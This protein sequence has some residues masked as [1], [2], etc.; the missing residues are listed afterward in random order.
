MAVDVVMGDPAHAAERITIQVGPIKQTLYVSD[1]E[2]FAK[3]GQVPTRLRLYQSLL[4]PEIR[5]VLNKRVALDPAMA[6]RMRVSACTFF[7]S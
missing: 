1:L 4:T 2:E 7:S 3:T 5:T 6:D